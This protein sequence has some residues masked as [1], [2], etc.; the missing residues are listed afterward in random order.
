MEKFKKIFVGSVMFTTIVT[1]CAVVVPQ[2]GATASAGDLIKM[3][4]LSS[5]YY[6][7]A[8]GK[9]YVFPNEQTYFSWYSDFSGVVTIPQ[10]E[11]E[12]YPLGANVTI[13]PGTKLVKITTDP[14]VYAVEPNGKLLW[15]PSE[16]VASTLYGSMWNK[17]I[18]DVPDAFFTNYTVESGQAS[19]SAYPVGSLVKWPS[20]A[21]VY[22]INAS[23]QAQKVA[24][25]AAFLA[26][27]FKFADVISAPASVAMPTLGTDIAAAVA[28][29]IDTSS[30]AGGTA[31]AGTGLTVALASDTPVSATVI[32]NT[33][34]GGNGQANVP[35][36]KINFTASPDGDVMVTQFRI[37]RSGISSDSDLDNLFLYDGATRLT[38]GSGISSNYATFNNPSGLFTVTKGTTKAITITGDMYYAATS[39]KTIGFSLVSAADVVT[40]G[41]AVSGSFPMTGNLMSTANAT[42]LGSV[43]FS[44]YTNYPAADATSIGAA[45]DQEVFRFIMTS[46]NQAL[47]VERLKLTAVGSIQLNDLMNFK[48]YVNGV[49]VGN[50]VTN[51]I[52][53][54]IVDFDLSASPL[55]I[56]KGGSRTVSLR[57]DIKSGSTRTFYFSFQNQN[58]IIV[59]DTGY[60]VLVEPYTNGTF[61]VIRPGTSADGSYTISAGD[62]S[63]TRSTISPTGSVAVDSTNVVLGVFDFTASGEDMKIQNLD[64]KADIDGTTGGHGDG[65]IDNGKVYFNDVQVGTT[66]DLTDNTDVNFTFGS[67]FIVPAGATSKVKIV[68]DIKTTSSTS[69]SGG[70]KVT[71][72]VA[73]TTSNVQR[74]TSLGTISR[75]TSDTPGNQLTITSAA[76]AVAKY[77]GLGNQTVVAGTNKAL[78]GSFVVGAGAA[79]GVNVNSITITFT[80]YS[81]NYASVTNMYL[82]DAATGAQL[83]DVKVSPTSSNIYTVNFNLPA[84]GS[85]VI[86]L[87]ANI[88][89]SVNAGPW[90]AHIG[91]D[92]TGVNTSV[93]VSATATDIQTM[94]VAA[95]GTLTATGGSQPDT[96][97]IL[98]GSTGNYLAQFTFNAANEGFII[99]KMKFKV[100]N[101]FATST[102]SITVKY[103]D[104]NG[105]TQTQQSL[106]TAGAQ[107]YA[108]ATYTG[109]TMYVP[110]NSNASID[111]YIDLTSISYGAASGANSKVYLDYDEG[112]NATGDSGGVQ[113]N[114]GASGSAD[115]SGN[116]FYVRKTKPTFAKL[117]AGTDPTAMLYKFSVVA[118]AA[119]N[120]DIKQLGFTVVT[121]TCDVTSMQLY[122]PNTSTA[123]TTA[124]VNPVSDG[125]AGY[126]KLIVGGKNDTVL[127]IGTSA[128]IYEVI[129][130]VTGFGASGD[131]IVVRFKQDTSGV[132]NS[133]AYDLG[134]DLSNAVDATKNNIWSDRSI[135]AHTTATLD[136]TN[137]YLLKDM[138]TS[139]SFSR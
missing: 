125:T 98:A 99:D 132:A 126:A 57:A 30:G 73:A 56:P 31:L 19:A 3:A 112:F 104:K 100:T 35:F 84:S 121:S 17:R 105:V 131:S 4:G 85:K 95:N 37:K 97:I 41:A 74:V 83:G 62:L 24:N 58:D 38:D 72:Y 70:E 55:A 52:T 10:S 14:K 39:G 69:F 25:E 16:A 79:D 47:S 109:M 135:S 28:T 5:V 32:T 118:D 94:T 33:D 106:F 96:A 7:G 50:T 129:G 59:R 80:S 115:L 18:I 123:L 22:Y 49:Q 89:A 139:Q 21:D 93:A 87:Y 67:S 29:L 103:P 136:W 122:D 27:R 137:G 71:V 92:G 90:A 20:A 78:L 34:S 42:D 6:L 127:T 111:V 133:D 101:N 68:G 124:A 76:L 53:G 11:L 1:M 8:D 54:N 77:V 44:G 116:L 102:A 60:N 15:V 110:A 26:N 107:A 138:S 48:L 117:D 88:K 36:L 113:T 61:T 128:K 13:R 81:T 46:T 91:S 130:T 66:K 119:G 86:N 120:V 65:G 45:D 63:I 40:N 108:T 9:R 2:A 23:G 82:T 64:I 51:M 43:A 75:P 114:T 12:S 134:A